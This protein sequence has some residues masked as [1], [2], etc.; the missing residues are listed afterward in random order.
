M[1]D[2][3]VPQD[4][5]VLHLR[6]EHEW[7]LQQ[8]DGDH[9]ASGEEARAR[10]GHGIGRLVIVWCFWETQ[11]HGEGEIGRKNK[12]TKN[13]GK[14]SP[15][16]ILPEFGIKSLFNMEVE[17]AGSYDNNDM[18]MEDMREITEVLDNGG[19]SRVGRHMDSHQFIL[20]GEGPREPAAGLLQHVFEHH[21]KGPDHGPVCERNRGNLGGTGGYWGRIV[22][23]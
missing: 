11:Q 16:Q 6:K 10:Q 1:R 2:R 4:A 23:A 14:R 12:G 9:R 17:E 13:R 3:A 21:D 22:S 18:D 8:G 20:P 5:E 15:S 7:L 19:V